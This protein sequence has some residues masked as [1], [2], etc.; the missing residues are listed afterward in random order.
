MLG[1]FYETLLFITLHLFYTN[2]RLF[3]LDT[4][5]AYPP[6]VI[7]TNARLFLHH[8]GVSYWCSSDSFFYFK[9]I[10]THIIS[11]SSD[12][13]LCWFHESFWEQDFWTSNQS[14]KEEG[15][16]KRS[17]CGARTTS[18]S[19]LRLG[20]PLLLYFQRTVMS[21]ISWPTLTQRNF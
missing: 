13:H 18:P 14:G 11:V 1:C 3:L 12:S 16:A 9:V 20:T 8:H 10:V 2:A 15:N 5:I 19:L 4:N 6:S 7:D 17:M 21:P